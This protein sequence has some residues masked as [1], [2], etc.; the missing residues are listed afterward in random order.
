MNDLFELIFLSILASPIFL[1]MNY[2]I[3]N[4]SKFDRYSDWPDK[5]AFIIASIIVS[6][7]VYTFFSFT[8]HSGLYLLSEMFSE[9]TDNGWFGGIFTFGWVLM[10]LGIPIGIPIAYMVKAKERKFAILWVLISSLISV[11]YLVFLAVYQK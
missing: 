5:I 4:F 2:I 7:A 10:I 1:G 9:V 6:F 3:D 11:M 8:T